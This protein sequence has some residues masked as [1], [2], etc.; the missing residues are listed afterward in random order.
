MKNKIA[1]VALPISIS[2]NEEFDYIIPSKLYD[3]LSVGSRVIVPFGKKIET[4]FVV[5][6]KNHSDF[7]DRLRPV[8]ECID[9][10]P[11]LNPCQIKLAREIKD[12]YLCSI[13]D[14]LSTI[15]PRKISGNKNPQIPQQQ[16]EDGPRLPFEFSAQEKEFIDLLSKKWP[17]VLLHDPENNNKF[18]AYSA[19]IKKTL[20]ESK[21]VILLVPDHKKIPNMLKRINIGLKPVILTSRLKNRES[22]SAWLRIKESDF[23]FVIG[24]RSAVFAPAKN[25]GL[26]IID[27]EEHFAYRQEQVPCY[28]SKEVSLLRSGAEGANLIFGSFMPSVES[29]AATGAGGTPKGNKLISYLKLNNSL[30][31]AVLKIIDRKDDIAFARKKIFSQVSE[32]QLAGA[33]QKNK[34]VLIFVNKLGFATYLYCKKCKKVLTCPNCNSSLKYRKADE[35]V[36][37]SICSYKTSA[38]RLCP[39]CNGSYI[40]YSGYGAEKVESE[41]ARLFPQ[42]RITLFD[43]ISSNID[44]YD[45]VVCTQKIF[46]EG[47]WDSLKFDCVHVLSCDE[48]LSHEDFRSSEKAFSKLFKLKFLAKEELVLDSKITEHYALKALASSDTES[49]FRDELALRKDLNL[50]PFI[51]MASLCFRSSSQK[52]TSAF[53]D[54]YFNELTSGFKNKKS[55]TI[56]GPMHYSPY[57]KFGNYREKVLI[58][59][60]DLKIIKTELRRLLSSRPSGVYITFD[61]DAL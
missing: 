57:M 29:Y 53:S 17:S 55:V 15:L 24:T 47:E 31:N 26:I 7:K 33:L 59:Y 42:K 41:L 37:C 34:K 18:T 14:A 36:F 49:F 4:G 60:K 27:E 23:C 25:L 2:L 52:K 44:D 20:N 32:Y 58:K 12:K 28:N 10:T 30:N 16:A 3:C 6:I 40:R 45:I 9:K 19:A 21:S 48:M 13:A 54:K 39:V 51:K 46:E 50:P 35:T 5:A 11:L 22:L 1:E 8:E 43:K 38:Y 61:P 56:L